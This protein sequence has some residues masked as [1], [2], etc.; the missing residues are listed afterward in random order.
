MGVAASAAPGV[1]SLTMTPGA[2]QLQEA[3]ARVPKE[4]AGGHREGRRRR[5]LKA[6]RRASVGLD[7]EVARLLT[8]KRCVSCDSRG[9]HQPEAEPHRRPCAWFR[10]SGP[11]DPR[12]SGNLDVLDLVEAVGAQEVDLVEH[13]AHRRQRELLVGVRRIRAGGDPVADVRAE[14]ACAVNVSVPLNSVGCSCT[15][16]A[17][18]VKVKPGMVMSMPLKSENDFLSALAEVML[19]NPPPVSTRVSSAPP[20]TVNSSVGPVC[21][22]TLPLPD[23][24][25]CPSLRGCGANVGGRAN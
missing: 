5:R 23:V 3:A 6:R 2:L 1:G 18:S 7:W 8:P 9:D 16:N 17:M 20:S 14:N 22:P 21:E 12:Q 15:S 10:H 13:A 24:S 11:H 4:D 25:L 19:A